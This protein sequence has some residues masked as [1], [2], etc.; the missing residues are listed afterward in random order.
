MNLSLSRRR[1]RSLRVAALSLGAAM[2][3]TAP[4]GWNRAIAA[5]K[6]LDVEIAYEIKALKI[7]GATSP[8]YVQGDGNK[9]V[10]S[11][12]SGAVLSAPMGG[13][14]ATTVAKVKNPGG[15]A[16]APAGFGSYAGQI[17]VL[18]VPDA[19]APCEVMRIDKSGA[20]SSFAKLPDA[21]SLGGGKATECRDLEFAASGPFAGK[22]YAVTNG[23]ATI[24]QID[25]GGKAKALATFDKPLAFEITSISFTG[26]DDKKAPNA[27]LAGMRP[28]SEVAAKVGRIDI[29]GTD[30]KLKGEYLVGFVSPTGWGWA[31]AG[32]GSYG[33]QLFIADAGKPAAKN[34]GAQDGSV[35]RLDNKG[36]VRPWASGMVDPNCMRFIGKTVVIADPAQSGKPGKGSIVVISSML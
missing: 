31:P 7:T 20:V 5:G 34:G 24:Y 28:K 18:S 2:L 32:F 1:I 6:G 14:K 29:L 23:N 21:G 19:K 3:T 15:V 35:Y 26:A 12:A 17:F 27:M 4:G 8:L 10:F 22:L 30:G 25:S 33:G 13:G 36:V 11:D 16:I 9:L